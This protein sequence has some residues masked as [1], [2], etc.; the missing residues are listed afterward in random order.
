VCGTIE[1]ITI[2]HDNDTYFEGL[3]LVSAI[4]RKGWKFLIN[5]SKRKLKPFCND[6][7]KLVKE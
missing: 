1:N 7:C 4:K 5:E 3:K 6:L 2:T